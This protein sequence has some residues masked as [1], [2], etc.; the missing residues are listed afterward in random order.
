M[1][2]EA[3]SAAFLLIFEVVVK[4]HMIDA[5]PQAQDKQC[6][7]DADPEGGQSSRESTDESERQV[8][9]SK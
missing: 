3:G 7:Q 6:K 5:V 1:H 9:A 8:P 4:R 2:I